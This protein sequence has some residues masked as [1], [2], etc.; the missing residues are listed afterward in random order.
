MS[1]EAS[2]QPFRIPTRTR[3]RFAELGL[4][5]LTG[6][7][8]LLLVLIMVAL[9]YQVVREAWPSIQAFGLHFLISN[10]WNAVTNQFGA[11]DLIWGTLITS[12]VSLVIAVPM[13]IAIG[14]F[15]SELAPRRLRT[16][17]A[18][19]VELLAA[20]PS[21][22]LGLWGILVM[23]PFLADHVEPFLADHVGFVPLFSGTPSSRG[24][25]PAC[26][27]LTIMIIPIVASISRE[28]FMSVP[29]DLKQGAMALGATRWEMVRSVSIPH[30]SGGLVA[31][32]MLG[33]GRAV[34]EAIAVTQVIGGTLGRQWSL[35]PPADTMA[36]RIAAQ[37]QGAATALQ[38]ASLA[39]LAVVLL[40][41]SL[42]TNLSAQLITRR[43]QRRLEGQAA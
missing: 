33:F 34:G 14:L 36:S 5:T 18:L 17:A 23:G 21:V 37:Y 32:T 2:P 39:Y 7:A 40:V 43:I 13:A 26:V 41:I 30:A 42:I 11:L 8:V 15:L 6:A 25:L 12:L 35:F 20:I 38:T 27:V 9:V 31:G 28:L 22:V 1:T 10:E 3:P 16:P 4:R 19:L 24:V 29:S